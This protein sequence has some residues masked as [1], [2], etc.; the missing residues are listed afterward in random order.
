MRPVGA[1]RRRLTRRTTATIP[2]TPRYNQSRES[3]G[4]PG[5]GGVGNLLAGPY[6]GELWGTPT[7]QLGLPKA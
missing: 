1:V 6:S 7:P 2:S 3:G 4:G 5:D